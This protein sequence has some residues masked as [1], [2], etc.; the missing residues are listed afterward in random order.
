MKR[1]LHT[2]SEDSSLTILWCVFFLS[3][4]GSD[5]EEGTC[6]LRLHDL[7]VFRCPQLIYADMPTVVISY[8]IKSRIS[9]TSFEGENI[10]R[11]VSF[12]KNE[13]YFESNRTILCRELLLHF[14]EFEFGSFCNR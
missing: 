12:R 8:H 10:E 6:P 3:L 9:T 7:N 4:L 11:I 13:K 14:L 1:T 2:N 5:T